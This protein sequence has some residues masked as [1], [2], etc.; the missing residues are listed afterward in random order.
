MI[1][2]RFQKSLA[3][4]AA[5]CTLPKLQ[6]KAFLQHISNSQVK[7]VEELFFNLLKGNVAVDQPTLEKLKRY[8]SKAKTLA[9]RRITIQKKKRMLQKGSGAPALVSLGLSILPAILSLINRQ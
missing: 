9:N 2:D 3:V 4:W 1:S 6:Q 8:K 5:F 7:D